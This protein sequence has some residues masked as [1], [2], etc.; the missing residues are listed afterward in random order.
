MAA[1]L[2]TQQRFLEPSTSTAA[3]NRSGNDTAEM[4]AR[5][6]VEAPVTYNWRAMVDAKGVQSDIDTCTKLAQQ[7]KVL[8][9]Q[10]HAQIDGLG[11]RVDGNSAR[12]DECEQQLHA[13]IQAQDAAALHSR[14]LAKYKNFPNRLMCYRL[15]ATMNEM[16]F[17]SCKAAVG[18]YVEAGGKTDDRDCFLRMMVVLVVFLH[19]INQTGDASKSLGLE[20]TAKVIRVCGAILSLVPGGTLLKAGTKVV[21]G[22]VDAANEVKRTNFIFIAVRSSFRALSLSLST[23]A[24]RLVAK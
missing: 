23:I 4:R 5:R 18:G 6:E 3:P 17:L 2:A 19:P 16:P 22:A 10:L 21:A 13:V 8:E 9:A 12:L 7:L 1:L 20:R 15:L 11:Q 24:S 14:A